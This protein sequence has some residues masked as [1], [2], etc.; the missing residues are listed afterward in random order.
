M[1]NQ[2]RC[3]LLFDEEPKPM[4][5]SFKEA[6]DALVKGNRMTPASQKTWNKKN[7]KIAP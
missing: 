2:G 7:R 1:S 6:F 4:V 5:K 3:A